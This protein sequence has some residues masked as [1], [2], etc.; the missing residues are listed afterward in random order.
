MYSLK[1]LIED[2]VISFDRGATFLGVAHEENRITNEKYVRITLDETFF[3]PD[4]L[5]HKSREITRE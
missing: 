5:W 1:N 4:V 3:K 2:I